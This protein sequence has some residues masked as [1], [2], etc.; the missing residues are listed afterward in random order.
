MD[1]TKGFSA[2]YYMTVVDG[3]TW[4]D[5]DTIQITDGSIKKES[6]GLLQSADVDCVRYA[7]GLEQWVRIWLNAEQEGSVKHVPLF[8]GL[9]CS[10]EREFNGNL[11]T[12]RLQCYSVLKP[13]DDVYLDRGWYA[14]SG[15]SG[16]TLV[17]QLLQVT[18]APITE[19]LNSP[20]LETS[21]IAEDNETMLSMSEKILKAINWRIKLNG[22]G[23]IR[24]CATDDTPVMQMDS[25]DYDIVEP[26]VTVKHDWYDCPNVFRAIDDDVMAIAR[27]D[28]E[29]SPLSTVN[30]GREVWMQET[31]C[32]LND[33][34]TVAEY[35]QRRLKEEQSVAM[36]LSYSRRFVPD[37][38]PTDVV[39]LHYPSIDI[40]YN[41]KIDSQT[42]NIGYG[43]KVS[44]GVSRVWQI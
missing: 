35:A 41:V 27:D 26:Q 10:P 23:E 24:I 13:A 44:E 37:V 1:W 32:N 30:R 36:Q 20:V 4:R 38:D 22:H 11:E 15:I 6:S 31:N 3:T 18:T 39:R 16:A 19:D 33:G 25:A 29:S 9:A 40:D 34:E 2:S 14:P 7:Q 42:I 8:T 21:I 43:S 12:N 28:D 5:I 17:R